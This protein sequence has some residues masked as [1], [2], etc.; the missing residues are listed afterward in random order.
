M[1]VR[2]SVSLFRPTKENPICVVEL[3]VRVNI[4]GEESEEPYK[5]TW[6]IQY[7]FTSLN[8]EKDKSHIG[9]PICVGELKVCVNI[10]YCLIPFATL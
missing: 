9:N 10:V 8:L 3:K 4:D 7:F 5:D 2:Y 6:S 1:I